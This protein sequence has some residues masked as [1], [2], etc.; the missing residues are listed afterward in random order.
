MAENAQCFGGGRALAF[1]QGCSQSHK[2]GFQ[3]IFEIHHKL[4]PAVVLCLL[5]LAV[6][7]L[8]V[9]VRAAVQGAMWALEAN[10]TAGSVAAVKHLLR[11]AAAGVRVWVIVQRA[12][13]GLGGSPLPPPLLLRDAR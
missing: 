5:I 3:I 2:S 10:L 11:A 1:G 8:C 12:Q 13:G 4:G 6:T 7:G 9:R